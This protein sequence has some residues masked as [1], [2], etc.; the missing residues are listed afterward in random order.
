M[1]NSFIKSSP[2]LKQ[3]ISPFI[4][5]EESTRKNSFINLLNVT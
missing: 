5:I 2:I 1:L 4:G 3:R